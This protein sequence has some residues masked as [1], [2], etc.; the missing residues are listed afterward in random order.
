MEGAVMIE[1]DEMI[2]NLS[3]EH[4]PE[5][6]NCSDLMGSASWCMKD[7][8]AAMYYK[9][10][11]AWFMNRYGGRKSNNDTMDVVIMDVL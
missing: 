8:R 10:A 7:L 11:L 9:N 3:G 1:I 2:A 4:L 6:S 5:W